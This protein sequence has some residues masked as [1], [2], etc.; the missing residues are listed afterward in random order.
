[1]GRMDVPRSL[2]MLEQAGMHKNWSLLAG[3]FDI[4]MEELKCS[5]FLGQVPR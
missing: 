2:S 3:G 1:M 5:Y 4:D